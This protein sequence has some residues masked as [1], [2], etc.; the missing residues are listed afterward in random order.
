MQFSAAL[1]KL[2]LKYKNIPSCL[3]CVGVCGYVHYLTLCSPRTDLSVSVRACC[4][5]ELEESELPIGGELSSLYQSGES[6]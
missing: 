6:S 3:S 2:T 4:T 5:G 1:N